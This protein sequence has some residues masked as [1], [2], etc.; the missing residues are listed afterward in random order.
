VPV[1][2]NVRGSKKNDELNELNVALVNVLP[3]GFRTVSTV[4]A[5]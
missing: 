4:S 1:A 5:L 2:G 3:S